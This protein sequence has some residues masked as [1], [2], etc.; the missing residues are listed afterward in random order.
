MRALATEGSIVKA[1]TGCVH[2]SSARKI[3]IIPIIDG[4]S[5]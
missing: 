3:N 2:D 1:M 4:K 5:S